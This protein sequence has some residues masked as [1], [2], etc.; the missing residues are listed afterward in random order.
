M[1]GPDDSLSAARLT[2]L[3]KRTL[4]VMFGQRPVSGTYTLDAPAVWQAIWASMIF[5]V[6]VMIYPAITNGLMV[7]FTR[8]T[9]QLLAV[10][11][12]VLIFIRILNNSGLSN[13][14]F[15]YLVPF[16]WVGNVHRLFGGAVENVIIITEDLT[17]SILLFGLF[18]WTVYWLWR[19]GRDQL[20]RDGWYAT[21][22]IFLSIVIDT[23]L[24]VFL[25]S[26]VHIP[27]G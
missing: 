21:G 13:R 15:A 27:V 2:D 8:L 19:I 12:T 20:G 3:V 26:R 25:M 1:T 17:Y 9:V 7:L 10:V 11:V 22:L 18:F 16:L 23:G 6:I 14:I 24:Q 5:T 4:M